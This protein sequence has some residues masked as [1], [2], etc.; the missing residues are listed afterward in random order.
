MVGNSNRDSEFSSEK[1]HRFIANGE[2]R[3]ASGPPFECESG[4]LD[5]SNSSLSY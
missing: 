4:L 3:S 2:Y 1:I 5:S